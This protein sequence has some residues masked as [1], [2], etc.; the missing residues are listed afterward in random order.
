MASRVAKNTRQ[1]F[2][3]MEL[4]HNSS[5]GNLLGTISRGCTFQRALFGCHSLFIAR[6]DFPILPP[7]PWLLVLTVWWMQVCRFTYSVPLQKSISVS[8]FSSFLWFVFDDCVVLAFIYLSIVMCTIFVCCS[9]CV[10]PLLSMMSP[11]S[12]CSIKSPAI[13]SGAQSMFLHN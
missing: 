3:R 10:F 6:G 13:S 12:L 7:R 1:F 2:G 4:T 5:L 8:R 9:R 11:V